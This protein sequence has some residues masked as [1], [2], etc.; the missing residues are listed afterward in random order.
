MSR[1]VMSLLSL[2]RWKFRC[3]SSTLTT[4]IWVLR[5]W[6]VCHLKLVL[7]NWKI[8]N[9]S[10]M[11]DLHCSSINV[12]W[13]CKT[14]MLVV[15]PLLVCVVDKGVELAITFW[16][17]EANNIYNQSLIHVEGTS[18]SSL[19]LSYPCKTHFIHNLT[20]R[21][22]ADRLCPNFGLRRW[23][24]WCSSSNALSSP[25]SWQLTKGSLIGNDHIWSDE[26]NW[27]H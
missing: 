16:S 26:A 10:I 11:L 5:N 6:H 27:N 22:W 23:K 19:V 18:S 1:L 4:S 7:C 24:S 21:P 8:C 20:F 14:R 12:G 3:S 15:S 17:I 9:S 2:S 13:L 25:C